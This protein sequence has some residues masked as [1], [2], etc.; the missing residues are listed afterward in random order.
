MKCNQSL[1]CQYHQE[2]GHTTEDCKTLWNHLEQLVKEGSLKQFLHQPSGQWGQSGLG[3][4]RDASS[5]APLGT[6]NVILTTLGRTDSHP[7]R[8]MPVTRPPIKDSK[9][10]LKNARI[11]I[12]PVLSFSDEDKI[13]TI[14]SHDDAPVVTLRIKGI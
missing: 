6:I 13:G 4:R 14:Q 8:V 9:F 1:H 12:R 3:P 11:E 7:F 2:R 10:E 5:K